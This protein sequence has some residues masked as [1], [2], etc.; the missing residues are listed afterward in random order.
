MKLNFND[1]PK[2]EVV[3]MRGGKGSVFMQKVFPTLEHTK[4]YSLI[5][6][7]KG[8]SI[9]VHTHVEDEEIVTCL[10]GKG[11]LIIDGKRYDFLP[12]DISLCKSG[13]NHSI[14]NNSEEDLVILAVINNI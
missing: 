14:E 4:V 11:N 1:I 5:T 9:G 7:P 6:I 2:T 13:R 10:K 8:C 3:N 12:S